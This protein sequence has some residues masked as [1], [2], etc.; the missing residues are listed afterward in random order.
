MRR[1]SDYITTVNLYRIMAD[2]RAGVGQPGIATGERGIA[3]LWVRAESQAIALERGELILAGR[4]YAA[5]GDLRSYLEELANDPL[6][7]SNEVE[8]AADRRENSVVAGYD[9]IK[10]QALAQGDGLHEIWLGGG[11]HESSRAAHSRPGA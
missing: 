5:V 9:A 4:Q 7:L 8:R 11:T 3:T 1:F 6:A 10:E 2:V